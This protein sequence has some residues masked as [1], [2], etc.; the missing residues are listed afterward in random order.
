[1][2]RLPTF[3]VI[4]AMKAGTTSLAAYLNQ[5]P[6]VAMSEKKEPNY[7]ADPGNWQRGLEWYAGLF[8]E[9]ARAA[10]EASVFYTMVPEYTGAP[11]RIKQTIPEVRIIYLVRDPIERM[12]SMF[13]HRAEKDRATGRSLSE[14]IVKI[15]SYFAIS[16]YD[17][18]LEPYLSLFD[19]EQILVVTTDELRADPDHLLARS[20]RHIGVTSDK[21]VSTNQILNRGADKRFL[22]GFGFRVAKVFHKTGVRERL[23]PRLRKAAKRTLSRKITSDM[24]FL[25]SDTERDLRNRLAPDLRIVRDLVFASG[26][27]VPSWLEEG[28]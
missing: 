14:T 3:I 1:M 23:P 20:F 26:A 24:L 4:G 5:H 27:G 16:R 28:R 22:S 17:F 11:E 6:E 12:K 10:G 19:R 7:F 21:R 9:G 8:P 25:D 2:G 13:V 15:P 18:Q